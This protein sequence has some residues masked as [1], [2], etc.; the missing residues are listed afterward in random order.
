MNTTLDLRVLFDEIKALRNAKSLAHSP[1]LNTIHDNVDESF[2]QYH[3]IK[4]KL[5]KNKQNVVLFGST[6]DFTSPKK[7]LKEI[8]THIDKHDE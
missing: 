4:I 6:T 3:T 1:M 7:A 8:L 5:S 2:I